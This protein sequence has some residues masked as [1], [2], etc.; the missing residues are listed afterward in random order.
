MTR[1]WRTSPPIGMTWATPGMVRI[2]GRTTK[3]AISRSSIG[4]DGRPC[5][6]HQH[7]LAHDRGD[8]PDLRLRAVRQPALHRR[9]TLRHLLPGAIDLGLPAELHVDDRQADAGGRANARH[10]GHAAHGRL[11]RVGDEL[12]H[13]LRRQALRLGDQHDRRPLRSGN[14]STGRRGST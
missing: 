7:D 3:S 10:A 11:D 1:Y 6:R 2:C 9:Q 13:L 12:L 5:D 4:A 8:R 14:T